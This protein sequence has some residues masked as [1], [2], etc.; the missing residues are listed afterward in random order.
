MKKRKAEYIRVV[1]QKVAEVVSKGIVAGI[2]KWA[3]DWW[4]QNM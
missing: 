3:L 2:V 4:L 1:L